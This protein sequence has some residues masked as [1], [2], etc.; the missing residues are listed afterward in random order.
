MIWKTCAADA[1]TIR[2]GDKW[3]RDYQEVGEYAGVAVA[4]LINLLS[5]EVVVVLGAG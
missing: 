3:P 1:Q 2:R 4:G 5:P